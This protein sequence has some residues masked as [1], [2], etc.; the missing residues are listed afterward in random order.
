VDRPAKMK[1]G[2]RTISE[3]ACWAWVAW[4][5]APISEERKLVSKRETPRKNPERFL[6]RFSWCVRSCCPMASGF[7][8]RTNPLD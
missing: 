2:S 8:W 1:L 5:E 3:K 7:A 6:R 4:A